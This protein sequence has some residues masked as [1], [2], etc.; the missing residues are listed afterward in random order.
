M[1]RLP[2]ATVMFVHETIRIMKC[3]IVILSS[4]NHWLCCF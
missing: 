4:L 2:G 3:A 1:L